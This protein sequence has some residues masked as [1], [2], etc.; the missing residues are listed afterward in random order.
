MNFFKEE[1]KKMAKDDPVELF[2]LHF[3]AEISAQIQDN[4]ELIENIRL[5]SPDLMSAVGMSSKEDI[6]LKKIKFAIEKLPQLMNVEQSKAK[7]YLL[8]KNARSDPIIHVLFQEASRFNNLITLI[9]NDLTAMENALKGNIVLTPELEVQLQSINEDKIPINWLNAYL[10]LKP[11]ASYILDLGLRVDF[12]KNWLANGLS[13]SYS[14]GYFSNP[15]GFINAIKQKHSLD[16]KIP[17][18]TVKLDFKV[19]N[20][21]EQLR[22][23]KT[24]YVIK[25]VWIEGGQ[26]DRKFSGMKDEN[27]QDLYT[28]MPLIVITPASEEVISN[29]LAAN[30]LSTNAAPVKHWFPLYYIPYR[31]DYLGRSSY[32]MD[33]QLNII[34]EKD[35][36]KDDNE[37]HAYWIKKATCLLLSKND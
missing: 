33:I 27:I 30:Q 11:F 12:F 22:G 21:D 14:L 34:K 8:D 25:G 2:G 13:P 1:V 17:F 23:N 6:L 18:N 20:D 7:I 31:G 36:E 16:Q 15:I 3:N 24:G 5:V 35:S 10:S 9:I 29:T 28:T 26:W 32:V 19:I 37:Y 4:L